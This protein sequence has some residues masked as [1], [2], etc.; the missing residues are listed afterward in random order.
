[1]FGPEMLVFSI[2]FRSSAAVYLS[3]ANKLVVCDFD[4][5]S[6]LSCC[7]LQYVERCSF[8]FHASCECFRFLEFLGMLI[9]RD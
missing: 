4:F 6:H 9:R 1:M 3:M 2:G 5:L 8:D 7:S